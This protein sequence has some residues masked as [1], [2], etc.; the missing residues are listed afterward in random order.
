M[1]TAP[2]QS[3]SKSTEF[4]SCFDVAPTEARIPICRVRSFREMLKA[5]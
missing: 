3:P 1:P 4:R 5:L 2:M